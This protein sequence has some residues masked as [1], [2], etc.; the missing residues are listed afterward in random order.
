M[1]RIENEEGMPAVYKEVKSKFDSIAMEALQDLFY[2]L[3][4]DQE[5]VLSNGKKGVIR[6]FIKPKQGDIDGQKGVPYA[7]IDIALDDGHLE[8]IIYQSGWGGSI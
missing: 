3:P 7:G 8:F 5:I 4:F 6:P 1:P 2:R